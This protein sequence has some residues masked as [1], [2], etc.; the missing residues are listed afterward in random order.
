MLVAEKLA[1]IQSFKYLS[2]FIE[3]T[4]GHGLNIIGSERMERRCILIKTLNT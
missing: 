4:H 2:H 3:F 1:D